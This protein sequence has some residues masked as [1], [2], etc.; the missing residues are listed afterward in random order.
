MAYSVSG[1]LERPR[2]LS[3]PEDNRAP[4]R[5]PCCNEVRTVDR[6]TAP[7]ATRHIQRGGAT[8]PSPAERVPFGR[9]T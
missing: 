5:A 2:L 6:S 3:G 4:T 9:V 1:E 8:A 7:T